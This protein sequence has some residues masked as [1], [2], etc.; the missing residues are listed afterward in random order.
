[1][2]LVATRSL[3]STDELGRGFLP[4]HD[5]WS[6]HMTADIDFYTRLALEADGPLVG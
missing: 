2:A 4:P 6:A 3:P 1:M 5:E